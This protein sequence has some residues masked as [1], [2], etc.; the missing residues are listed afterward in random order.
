MIIGTSGDDTERILYVNE[1]ANSVLNTH[2]S[3]LIGKRLSEFMPVPFCRWHYGIV[4]K[5]CWFS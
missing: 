1:M 4:R 3:H 5:F 2:P